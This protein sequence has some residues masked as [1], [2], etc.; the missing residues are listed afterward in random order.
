MLLPRSLSPTLLISKVSVRARIVAIAVLPLIGFAAN[1]VAFTSSEA[2][3]DAAFQSVR[4]AASLADASREFK[5]ALTSMRMSA[6]DFVAQ[7][8]YDLVNRFDAGH[9]EARRNLDRIAAAVAVDQQ[10]DILALR[11]K[12]ET[13]KHDFVNLTQAQEELGFT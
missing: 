4:Q 2:E 5:V 10:S 11:V 8:S 6:K 7:P 9:D 13:L 12:V 3:V 1:G